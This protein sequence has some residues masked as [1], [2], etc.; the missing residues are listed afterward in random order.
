MF[1]AL[2]LIAGWLAKFLTVDVAKAAFDKAILYALFTIVLPLVLW[3]LLHK[4]LEYFIGR[5]QTSVGSGVSGLILEATGLLAWCLQEAYIPLCLSIIV[6]A[7][8]LR[9]TLNIMQLRP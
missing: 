5:M 1:A 4:V 6:S 3:N 9:W 2:G 8:M 7:L